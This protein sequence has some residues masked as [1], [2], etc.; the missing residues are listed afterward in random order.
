M[1]D[2]A[3]RRMI[4]DRLDNMYDKRGSSDY[5]YDMYD[6]ADYRRGVRGSGRRDRRDYA[7]NRDYLDSRDY[8]DGHGSEMQLTKQDMME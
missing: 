7:D 2:Y 8:M 1:N 3:R 4:S 6:G 5:S